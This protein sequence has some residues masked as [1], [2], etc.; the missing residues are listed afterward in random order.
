MVIPIGVT[1]FL[2]LVLSL[3]PGDPAEIAMGSGATKEQL[4]AFRIKNGLDKPVLVQY[5]F[6]ISKAVTGGLGTS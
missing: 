3:T 4:E 6:Y 5:I 2:F 1:L